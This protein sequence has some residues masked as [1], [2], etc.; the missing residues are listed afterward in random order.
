MLESGLRKL[1]RPVFM[2]WPRQINGA[3]CNNKPLK[4]LKGSLLM[5]FPCWS[6]STIHD[7]VLHWLD[8]KI[9]RCSVGTTRA[10]PH[11]KWSCKQSDR[12]GSNFNRNARLTSWVTRNHHYKRWEFHGRKWLLRCRHG[13]EGDLH[14]GRPEE[15]VAE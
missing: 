6:T 7:Q 15:I 2:S 1:I 8:I 13:P 12:G 9:L 3:L 14:R 5:K 10:R 11:H 4:R